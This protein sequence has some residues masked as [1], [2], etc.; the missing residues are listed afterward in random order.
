M[1]VTFLN[2]AR[3]EFWSIEELFRIIA[4]ALPTTVT[5]RTESVPCSGAGFRALLRN[6]LWSSQISDADIVHV[7]GDIHYAVIG[8]WRVPSVLT[9]HDLRFIENQTGLRRFLFWLLW[10]YLPCKRATHVTVIS[11]FTKRR[12]QAHVRMATN[13]LHVIPD[14]VDPS[15]VSTPKP[16]LSE[17]PVVLHVGTTPNKNLERLIAACNGL[18][19][20][21]WILGRLTAE[22]KA[23]LSESSIRVREHF[24]LTREEVLSLYQQCDMVSFVSLYE[25]FGLPI[26]EA[27]AVGRPVITSNI[28]P[29]NEVAGNG[30]LC[31]VPQD[32][33]EIHQALRSL[34][35]NESLRSNLVQKGFENVRN[36]SAQAVAQQFHT[37]YCQM[38][39]R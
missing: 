36:Y 18:N 32:V 6:V 27:Q 8:M 17:P 11:E 39:G 21:L 15:F 12:L 1:R 7:T 26:L 25:G 9:I 5:T 33:A 2:R 34:L 30:A 4:A 22:Q 20:E 23:L 29:L 10:L 38:A 14:C 13:K 35:E 24:D 16:A 31:V 3:G 37:L 28:A 19:L